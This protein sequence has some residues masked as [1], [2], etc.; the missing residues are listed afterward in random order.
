MQLSVVHPQKAARDHWC[1]ALRALL[2]HAQ[3]RAWPLPRSRGK[4]PAIEAAATPE[5]DSEQAVTHFGVGWKPPA[6]YFIAHPDLAA[7][8]T[9]GAGVDHL[10]DLDGLPE[11]LPVIRLEDA[12]MADQMFLYCLHEILR[13]LTVAGEYERQQREGLWRELESRPAASLRVGVFG[14]GA[15]GGELARR[16]AAMGFAVS[17][18][19]R[20]P[21]RIDGVNCLHGALQWPVFLA[22]CDVLILMA[23]L[24]AQTRGL[25][26][27]RALAALPAGAWLINVARGALVDEAALLAALDSGPI[28][29]ATLDVF[30]HE[31]LPAGHAFW[32]H[33]RIRLTPHVAAQTLIAPSA[34][35]VADKILRLQQGESVSGIVNRQR[36]Y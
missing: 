8:F 33:P 34:R 26:D 14:L 35:Q 32:Q 25:I 16:L 9:A 11:R 13:R 4:S 24:T 20:S 23:P 21:H 7:F 29:G 27:E 15:L 6:E 22:G 19:A 31:P 2:P 17:G 5:P 18:F 30:Q 12:G 3:V 28:A 36:G 1:R 10:L